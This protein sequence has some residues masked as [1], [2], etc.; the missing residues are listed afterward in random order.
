MNEE[1][2]ESRILICEMRERDYRDVGNTKTADRY[3]NEKY[4]WEKLINKLN[5]KRNEQLEEYKRRYRNL[6][7]ALIDIR[8]CCEENSIEVNTREYGNLVVTNIDDI[9]QIINKVL[10]DKNE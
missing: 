1:E 2:I 8:E 6:E 5:P 3:L 9:L 7:Q 4:K 10:G